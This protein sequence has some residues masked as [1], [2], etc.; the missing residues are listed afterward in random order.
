[1]LELFYGKHAFYQ[2]NNGLM[3]FQMEPLESWP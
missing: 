1:M 2:N 3:G